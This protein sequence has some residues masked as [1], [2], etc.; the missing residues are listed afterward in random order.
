[1]VPI[2][3]VF[4]Y[5]EMPRPSCLGEEMCLSWSLSLS[6]RRQVMDRCTLL[7]GSFVP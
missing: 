4:F 6:L 7:W 1:M 2:P 5:M 3:D